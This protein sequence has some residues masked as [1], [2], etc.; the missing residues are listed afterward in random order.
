MNTA[1]CRRSFNL[2]ARH[3]A[4]SSKRFSWSALASSFSSGVT[5]S[6]RRVLEEALNRLRE[7]KISSARCFLTIQCLEL[8]LKDEDLQADVYAILELQALLCLD[9]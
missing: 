8:P 7:P 4:S 1:T 3:A 9:M 6:L 5:Y 2:F